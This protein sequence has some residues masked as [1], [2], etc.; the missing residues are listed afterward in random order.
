M[1]AIL[2][3]LGASHM[4]GRQ[5]VDCFLH[6]DIHEQEYSAVYGDALAKFPKLPMMMILLLFLQKQNLSDIVCSSIG[7]MTANAQ[8]ASNKTRDCW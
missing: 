6:S 2:V 5:V 7:E 1:V 4:H 3:A 8:M